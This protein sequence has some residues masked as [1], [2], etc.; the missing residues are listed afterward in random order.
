MKSSIVFAALALT[1]AGCS[2]RGPDE[3]RATQNESTPNAE[4]VPATEGTGVE[5]PRGFID[6]MYTNGLPSIADPVGPVYTDRLRD[7]VAEDARYAEASGGVGRLDFDYWCNCPGGGVSGVEVTEAPV[8]GREDRR[9][10]TARFTTAG[11]PM[12]NRFFFE[13]IDELWYLDEVANQ[14]DPAN[15]PSGW[16][17]SQI[18]KYGW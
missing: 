10:V 11:A 6:A 8:P 17:L 5:D 9:V 13:R 16:T 12:I 14:S 18:L 7:L 15:E 2:D 3:A 1:L 4:E